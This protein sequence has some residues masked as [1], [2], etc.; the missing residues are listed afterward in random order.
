L[1]NC[2]YDASV[3]VFLVLPQAAA[4]LSFV[5]ATMCAWP[6]GDPLAFAAEAPE[7]SEAVPFPP[8]LRSFAPADHVAALAQTPDG[9]LWLGTEVGL[10]AFDGRSFKLQGAPHE[11]RGSIV[12]LYTQADGALYAGGSRGLWRRDGASGR[13]ARV[14]QVKEPVLA[15]A[16]PLHG[17]L[18]VGGKDSLYRCEG[19]SCTLATGVPP[20]HEAI[21]SLYVDVQRHHV[22][23]GTA[24]G[25]LRWDHRAL[26]GLWQGGAVHAI[27]ADRM[28][29]SS[30]PP[31]PAVFVVQT[32][33]ES[34]KPYPDPLAV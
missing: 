30:L 5:I 12:A 11:P 23:I 14:P 21:L 26:E 9:L 16:G 15:L 19:A 7:R 27:A 1:W 22:L 17:G 32:Q 18:W 4:L 20:S 28:E 31:K 8:Q 10:F 24:G 6:L 3:D 34:G 25:L 2:G 33:R 13:F 29:R